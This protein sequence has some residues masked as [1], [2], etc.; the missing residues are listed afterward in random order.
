MFPNA[1]LGDTVR[2]R[3]EVRDSVVAASYTDWPC[4]PDQDICCAQNTCG[5]PNECIRWTT[6]TVQFQP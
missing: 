5:G 1:L 2:L 3:L 4:P 6:W